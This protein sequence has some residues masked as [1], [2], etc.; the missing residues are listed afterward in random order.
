ML[1]WMLTAP[2]AGIVEQGCWRIGAGEGPV[3]AHINPQARRIG[4]AL[5]HDRHGR[6]VAMDPGCIQHMGFDPPVERHECEGGG[7]DLIGQGRGAERYAF[8]GEAL[9]LPVEGLVL[10]VLLKK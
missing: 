5:R 3:I 10:T 8:A 1:P 7:T 6:I 4:L 9:G 2:I